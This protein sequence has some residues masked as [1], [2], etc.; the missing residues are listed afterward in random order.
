[1]TLPAHV[2]GERSPGN[3]GRREN[4]KLHVYVTDWY[5]YVFQNAEP[6]ESSPCV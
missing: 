6:T 3:S 1:M 4:S 5:D 2:A